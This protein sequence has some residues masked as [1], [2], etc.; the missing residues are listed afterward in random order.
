VRALSDDPV[1]AY[2]LAALKV[3]ANP[4]DDANQ[5]QFLKVVLP[6]SLMDLLRTKVEQGGE[7][8]RGQMEAHAR[9]LS[10]QDPGA[11]KLWR[12]LFALRNLEAL[13]HKHDTLDGLVEELL[14]QRVGEYRTL[15]EERH[16]DLTDPT[17]IDGVA[18]LAARLGKALDEGTQVWVEPMAGLEIALRGVLHGAGFG[19]FALGPECPA[20]AVAVR[21]HDV[22][23]IGIALGLFKALQVV[24]TRRSD[25][26]FRDF[27]AVDIE[28]T[29]KDIGSAE[30]VDLAAVRVRDGVIVDQ[31]ESLVKPRVPIEAAAAAVTGIGEAEVADAPRFE[32]V[33]PAFRDF[34]GSDVVVAH[35]G[36]AFDF[37]ILDRMSEP[38]GGR[39]LVTYD[40]LVLARELHPGSRRLG[41]LASHFKIEMGTAHR[42]MV[43]SLALAKVFLKL[44]VERLARARKTALPNLLDWL[45]IALALSGEPPVC[46][47]Q[48]T[49]SD[50]S[51]AC[52]EY[53]D[54]KKLTAGYALGRYSD[55]LEQY[56]V[57][58]D[59]AGDALLPTVEDLIARLGGQ[60]RLER[61][62]QERS[63]DDRY[64]QAMA[65][66]RRLLA[67]CDAPIL[68]AQIGQ[69]LELVA[70][71]R[72]D[73]T[74]VSQNRVSL[75][76]LHSTKGLEF[77][78]VYIIGV[79]DAELPGMSPHKAASKL[80][81]EEGR[82]VLYVGMT[83][84]KDRLVMTRVARRGDLPTGGI[85]YLAEM[86]IE[87]EPGSR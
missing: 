76:T 83:R 16:E 55:A 58:R 81:I 70:L 24:V 20:D 75:L 86:G 13:G 46:K 41:D 32:E 72:Q 34:C 54:L 3:I 4:T 68:E 49:T 74:E 66:L 37:P 48:A 61:L 5:E 8:L 23:G 17:E 50:G 6:A 31:W 57:Q 62:R 59:L 79:E 40:T 73:G 63:A 30:I 80:E 7:L 43:D 27:T 1:I 33:W 51:P 77:S 65:R 11:R 71:S 10:K 29:G 39:S 52:R 44:D 64:P 26:A 18:F 25:S 82:R 60:K 45:G 87:P 69:L 42:A 78:R 56:G 12:G 85:Q 2:V 67:E 19:R 15:L 38:L 36:Y 14:S 9:T 28:T 84:V 47:G 53:R 22:P 35:N 21:A